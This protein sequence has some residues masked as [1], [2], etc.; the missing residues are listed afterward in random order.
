VPLTARSKPLIAAYNRKSLIFGI[1]GIV[2]HYAGLLLVMTFFLLGLSV[3]VVGTI[4]L[5]IG[6][7]F[8]VKAKKRSIAWVA[9]LL[10]PYLGLLFLALL[11]DK[12]RPLP[13]DCT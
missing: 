6:V 10:I 3:L 11:I 13:A 4:L 1:P 8:Y 9:L 7:G 2:L 12:S 5:I